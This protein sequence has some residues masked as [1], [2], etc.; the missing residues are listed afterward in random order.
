VSATVLLRP[1]TAPAPPK[2][3][4]NVSVPRRRSLPSLS[5]IILVIPAHNEEVGIAATMR[6]V[7]AQTV[8]P[9][10]RIVVSD[11]STDRT[12]AIARSRPGWEVWETMENRGKKGGAL[13]QAWTIL[14]PTLGDHDYVVTMDADT[15]LDPEFVDCAL[16]KYQEAHGTGLQLGGVCANFSGLPLDTALGV[17]QTME[18]ARAEKISRSRRGVAPVLA[19]A[20]T[21][22]SV[23]ALRSVYQ[24][25]GRLYEPVL[26]EDYELSLAL[27]VAGYTTMA[28]RSCK[29]QTDLMPTT[30]MLW[31]Q[32]LR[33]YRG[34]FESLR[35]Y[36]FRRGIRSDIAWLT[37]SLW[38]AA[39]RWLFLATLLFLV[40]TIG[41]VAF[42][43]WL[44]L[45]F[46]FASVIRVV[47][48]KE[49][50]WQ[51][52]LIAALMVEELYYAF[53]LEAVLWRSVYL[54]FFAR[55][56]SQW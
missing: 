17:L 46:A 35:A 51:Y 20:A 10:R 42:S 29:A 15:L 30:R 44:L 1:E 4:A 40:L 12:V 55:G 24:G 13:N 2:S 8:Q 53:F 32:R 6:S 45:L 11:N 47:Q 36:G 23:A 31:A 39:S 25:R 50:G 38:A 7:E 52:M 49:L 16:A 5:R 34:A 33:W 54:A 41:H 28:P 14:E 3:R 48:V 43:P 37:F 9:H 19:G 27:R 21:M 56:E 18:Y 26:T 22:F